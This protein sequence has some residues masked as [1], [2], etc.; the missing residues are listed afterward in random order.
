MVI[1]INFEV[2]HEFFLQRV[3]T[4]CK[5]MNTE[6]PSNLKIWSLRGISNDLSV[7]LK[8]L[9]ER[10]DNGASLIVIDPIYKGL[11][12]RDENSAGDMG[13]LMNE[14]EA[15][16]EKTGAAVAFAAHYSKGNQ[17]D[18]DPLD[19]V[20]GSGVFARDPDTI[21]GLTAHEEQNCFSVHS[22]L[23]NFA[24][25]DPFVVEWDFPLFSIREDLD[26]NRLK[27]PNQKVTGT[28]VIDV[29]SEAMPSG[30][31]KADLVDR[32]KDKFSIGKSTVYSQVKSLIY[33]GK[34]TETAGNLFTK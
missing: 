32:C 25:L 14:V 15:I 10:L 16:V 17:A 6:P 21:M 4:V 26:A 12:G 19:R 24:G 27:K 29:I 3:R 30:I 33:S 8:A 1:F 7:I 13:Q 22:A 18:K 2:A 34:V 20:S 9:D 23:R 28:Q 31:R 11:A 5:A